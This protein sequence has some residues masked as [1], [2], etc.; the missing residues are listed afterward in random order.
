[1]KGTNTMS[2]DIYDAMA[3]EAKDKYDEMVQ[4]QL[5][6]ITGPLIREV[7]S[8]DENAIYPHPLAYMPHLLSVWLE[9]GCDGLSEYLEEE[10]REE[11]EE[12]VRDSAESGPCC[13]QFSCPCGNSNGYRG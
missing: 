9:D 5:D 3:D 12:A 10:Y 7:W 6:Q 1:M 13:Y 4:D 2:Y 8:M 11:A